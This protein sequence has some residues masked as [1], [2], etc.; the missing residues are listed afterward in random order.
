MVRFATL[1]PVQ[2]ASS[3]L[4]LP[5]Q[6]AAPLLASLC[7]VDVRSEAEFN[8]DLGHVP[9]AVNLPLERLEEAASDWPRHEPV[10]LVCRAG[11]RSMEAARRL[12]GMGFSNLVVLTGGTLLWKQGQ[13]A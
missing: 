8:N 10:A 9:G 12:E 13:S 2:R 1:I 3:V 6:Q 4:H 7:V 11:A 5:I